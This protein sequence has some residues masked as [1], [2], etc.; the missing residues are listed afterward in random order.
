[1]DRDTP[2][3][4]PFPS[5]VSLTSPLRAFL[6]LIG[7]S[8][9]RQARMRQMVW[10]ALGLLA[11]V[12]TIVAFTT[13]TDRWSTRTR[14][15]FLRLHDGPRQPFS[16]S[17]SNADRGVVTTHGAVAQDLTIF[18]SVPVGGAVVESAVAAGY[19][20]I[21]A[22]SA[23]VNFSRWLMFSLFLS[24]LVPL[25]TLS[26]ATEAIGGEREARSLVWLLTR[27]LPRPMIYLAKFLGLL[28]WVLGL[29]LG[30]FVLI[31]LAAG[32][33]GRLALRLYWPA[34]LAG[35]LAFAALFHLIG[36][37][38][39][40]PTV[41]ALVYS[42]FLETLL[43]DMPGLMKRISISFYT[44]CLMFEEAGRYGMTPEKPSVYVP[45]SG[46]VA[47]AVLLGLT[48]AFLVVG[49][50]LFSRWEYRD[51]V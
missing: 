42:F 44:R 34:V 18:G 47:W 48:A 20:A 43:G 46:P 29:N 3:A 23:F 45:V 1:M 16:L 9:R 8:L 51:D 26:F 37:L 11:L 19:E 38:F 13:A 21:L 10:I 5:A 35:S 12:V 17:K 14:R 6:A 24:F 4:L 49:M 33:P 32:E 7:L 25:W 28:P 39:R 31:C 40:R 27:P 2:A 30:G 22:R 15:A 41:I 36:A 50:V